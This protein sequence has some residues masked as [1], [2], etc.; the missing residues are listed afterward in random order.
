[1]TNCFELTIFHDSLTSI[2]LVVWAKAQ[3]SHTT[4]GMIYKMKAEQ[5]NHVMLFPL[6]KG[7]ELRG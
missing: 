4:V 5:K 3:P 6:P 7:T 2:T 1:M